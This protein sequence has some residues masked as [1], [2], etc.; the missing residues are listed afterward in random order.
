MQGHTILKIDG[1]NVN[2]GGLVIDKLYFKDEHDKKFM[3][4]ERRIV[5]ATTCYDIYNNDGK[6]VAKIDR[7]MFSIT[8]SYKFYYEGDMNPFPDYYA[9]GSF[10]DRTYTFKAG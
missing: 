2:L 4:V 3:S 1:N 7:E 8:P 9:E 10:L 5:A 6:C